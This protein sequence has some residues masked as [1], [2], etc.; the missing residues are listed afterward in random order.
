[1]LVEERMTSPAVTIG[2]DVGVQEALAMMHR[3]KCAAF[4]LSTGAAT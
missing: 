1:M 2:P 4:R 3:E